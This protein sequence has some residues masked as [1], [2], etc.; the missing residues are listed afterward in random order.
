MARGAF[1][2]IDDTFE[3]AR[4][5][6]LKNID[7]SEIPIWFVRRAN[8][9]G[10]GRRVDRIGVILRLQANRGATAKFAPLRAA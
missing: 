10:E 7:F 3:I 9:R 2:E 4:I 6:R 8:D 5:L 1:E